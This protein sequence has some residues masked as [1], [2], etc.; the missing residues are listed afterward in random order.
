MEGKPRADAPGTATT[1]SVPGT[2]TDGMDPGV[3]AST[4]VVTADNVA[5][6]VA[7]AGIGGPPQQASP[8]ESWRVNFFYNDVFTWSVSDA[9]GS[10]LYTVQ[11]SPQ[12]NPF[13]QVLSQMYAGW[14]GGMQFR[15]IVAGSGIFGGRLVCAIIPP[16]IQIQ[17]GLEV[18]QFPHVVIDARSLEPVTITMPDLR[19]EMYHPTGNP[20][21]VP[22]LVVSVY[23]NLIN[24]FGGT[25]SA[26]QVTVETRPSEDFEFVLI[27]APSSRTVESVNPSWLLTTPVLTGAGSD[28]R[29]GAPIV[30]LQPVPGG[31]STCNRHW[32][33]NGETYGW[34]SPR[35]DDIDHPSGNVSYPTG[36]ATN[37]IE[38]W[39]AN[40]GTATTN[41]IS[42]IAPDGFP[43]MGAIPFSGTTIPT[44]AWV[45]FGQVWNASN[46]T[47]YVG[48]VQAYELGFANGAPSNIRPVTTTTGAQLVA[49][50]IY[51]VAIAQNQS[52]AGIFFMSKG[53]VSTPGTAATTYTPQP[54]AIVTTP[55]TPVAAPIGKNTPIM[56]SAVVR[57]TGDVNAGPGSDNGT[58]YGVGSQPLSVTLGLSLTNYSSAL[59]PGQFFVWQLNFAS[60]FMEIG[61]NTDGY[62]YAGTGAY[63]GMIEL[64][65]LIDVR[66]VGVRPN[67]S[68]LVFNLA[69]VA[70]TGYSYG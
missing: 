36:S 20:G 10:I 42:N 3:V 1:A 7:T 28:N 61:L 62:F 11:H 48:T 66:P 24:P 37:T 44:G 57:R 4:D 69:G 43:D 65:D 63:S 25:T 29:W 22:T 54:S 52:S 13:T 40:A 55:G 9:P 68:T 5:A 26:I 38:T 16:G 21:L 56:F 8:Q 45:G 60:G 58:Q 51:G 23:N 33:M 41:P 12:N 39:Y 31:F 30:G 64:T 27:R 49:K 70:N 15:F 59:Q 47:P 19:P 32:N 6:S 18:R 50:S 46:G 67:T 17:P 2:T 14:A 35:F 53:M 34:S